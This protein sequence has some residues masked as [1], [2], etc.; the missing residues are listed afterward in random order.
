M[1]GTKRLLD[2]IGRMK[3]AI[4]DAVPKEITEQASTIASNAQSDYASAYYVG[5]NDITVRSERD[6]NEWSITAS[7]TALLFVE[8][9]TGI[10]FARPVEML[11][12]ASEYPAK[13]WSATHRGYLTNPK[14]FEKWNG[15]W[16]TPPAGFVTEGNPPANVMYEATKEVD[17]R[18]K[19]NVAARYTSAAK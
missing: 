10:R 5:P 8:F 9:G 13:S 7:G 17:K 12:L 6:G 3:T 18:I 19:L 14:K 4:T 11:E 15:S 2:K 1:V 16:P